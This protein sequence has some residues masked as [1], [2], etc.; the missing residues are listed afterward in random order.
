MPANPGKP[1]NVHCPLCDG[2]MTPRASQH[3]KFWGCQA[4]PKCKG[5]RNVDGEFVPRRRVDAEEADRGDLPSRRQA[6]ND[7][8]RWRGPS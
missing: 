1:E 5:T 8:S 6:E 7:R 2:P 3:G 4:Y